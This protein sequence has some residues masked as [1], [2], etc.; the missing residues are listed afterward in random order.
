MDS[1]LLLK[2]GLVFFLI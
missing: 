1:N 2:F